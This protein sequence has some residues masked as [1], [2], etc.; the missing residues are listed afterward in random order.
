MQSAEPGSLTSAPS[1]PLVAEAELDPPDLVVVM[2]A[3]QLEAEPV[4]EAPSDRV[5]LEHAHLEDGVKRDRVS[6]QRAPDTAAVVLRRYE[7]PA[8]LGPGQR[9]PAHDPPVDLGD[10]RVTPREPVVGQSSPL[11]REEL[12][13]QKGVPDSGGALPDVERFLDVEAP[14]GAEV[15]GW[16]H[17]RL[18]LA[19]PG[20]WHSGRARGGPGG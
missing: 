8:D 10:R 5:V 3:D 9:D 14:V 6:H 18:P 17:L 11:V 19:A 16:R 1:W 7:K 20:V 15:D 12:G 2:T 4:V 13:I